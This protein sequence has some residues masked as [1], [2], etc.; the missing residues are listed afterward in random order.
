MTMAKYQNCTCFRCTRV[1]QTFQLR[2]S[3]T[4]FFSHS[5]SLFLSPFL[6]LQFLRKNIGELIFGI[7]IKQNKRMNSIVQRTFR[8]IMNWIVRFQLFLFLATTVNCHIRSQKQNSKWTKCQSNQ[9]ICH[10]NVKKIPLFATCADLIKIYENKR[11]YN[12]V[13]H[14]CHLVVDG[15][16]DMNRSKLLKLVIPYFVL[17]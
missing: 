12:F 9:L 8:W 15:V 13:D 14:L 5:L 4:I 10:Q 7:V 6:S 2:I 1:Q 3:V 11:K 17:F 16:C